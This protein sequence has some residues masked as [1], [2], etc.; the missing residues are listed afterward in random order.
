MIY[1]DNASTTQI[2]QRVLQAMMPYLTEEYGN[3]GTLYGLGKRAEKAVIESRKKVADF[4]GAKPEQ[5]I[6]TSGGSEANNLVFY[7]LEKSVLSKKRYIITSEIEH[8]SLLKAAKRTSEDC[9]IH[10]IH[11]SPNKTGHI[12][13]RLIEET[14]NKYDGEIGLVSIMHTNNETGISNDITSIGRIC[15][16]HK[17]LFH[18]DCVQAAGCSMLNVNKMY[19]DFLSVSSHKIHGAKGI[20]ALYAK[21]RSSL[22]PLIL[23]GSSQEYGIRGGTENVAGIVGFGQ[24]CS[25]AQEFLSK[26]QESVEERLKLIIIDTLKQLGVLDF[27]INGEWNSGKTMSIYFK[28]VD[29][30]TLMLMLDI[31]GVCVSSGSACRSHE[32]KPSKV[33]LAMGVQPEVA[34][35]SIRVSVSRM[36]TEKEM[37]QAAEIIADCVKILRNQ[38]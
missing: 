14:L 23:G 38:Y 31:R 29:A 18:T 25:I 9:K 16:R 26:H 12:E 5:I 1:L 20:G 4:I 8:D 13:S 22:S 17:V 36:N 37:I 19:C 15:Q 27:Y 3:P 11:L 28:G 7:G 35:S 30:E 32:N 34:R 2:D 6:F 33:L 10:L 21:N 24:A